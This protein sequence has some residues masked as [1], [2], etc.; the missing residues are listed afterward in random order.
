LLAPARQPSFEKEVLESEGLSL[1]DSK[2]TT[3]RKI[4]LGYVV[5][6]MLLGAG[7]ACATHYT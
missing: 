1:E 4:F 7:G 6:A 5:I 3:I 2:M